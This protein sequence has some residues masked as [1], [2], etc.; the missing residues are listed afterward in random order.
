MTENQV[1]VTPWDMFKAK[2]KDAVGIGGQFVPVEISEKR[3]SICRSC[4]EFRPERNL[5]GLKETCNL[6]GCHMPWK[7]TLPQAY[8]PMTP[9]KWESVEVSAQ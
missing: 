8:C 7:A 6:C 5:A 4:P 2:I 3:L 1:P 9:P